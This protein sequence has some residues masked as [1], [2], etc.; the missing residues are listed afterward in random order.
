MAE[1]F[2]DFLNSYLECKAIETQHI[3]QDAAMQDSLEMIGSGLDS[4]GH[5]YMF[6]PEEQEQHN[7]FYGY[8][9]HND[10]RRDD[11]LYAEL[12]EEDFVIFPSQIN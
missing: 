7:E 2:K 1:T 10:A 3:S 5:F 11:D 12:C 6:S 8:D 4:T 9:S